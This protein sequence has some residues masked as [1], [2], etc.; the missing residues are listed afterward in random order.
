MVLGKPRPTCRRYPDRDISKTPT[1]ANLDV[2][3]SAR[4]SIFDVTFGRSNLVRAP[5]I[6]SEIGITTGG[7]DKVPL[8]SFATLS[9]G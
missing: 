1:V 4:V 7:S 6:F 2:S 5:C 3:V 9:P 8:A